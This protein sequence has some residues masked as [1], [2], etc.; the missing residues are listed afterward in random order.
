MPLPLPPNPFS[1]TS[2]C[3]FHLAYSRSLAL[4]SRHLRVAQGG[5]MSVL[6]C[7]RLLGRMILEAPGDAGRMEFS[8]E[9]SRC[10]DDMQLQNVADIYKDHF[11]RICKSKLSPASCSSVFLTINLYT[12]RRAKGRTPAPF[13]H[14]SSSSFNTM[15]NALSHRLL[16]SPRTQ[17]AVKANVCLVRAFIDVPIS[18]LYLGLRARPLPML[19]FRK[20]GHVFCRRSSG[21]GRR[22]L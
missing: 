22:H 7:A 19:I 18:N 21:C 6:V 2:Q 3:L 9:V 4:E 20:T 14:P 8:R 15:Q 1:A 12:V 17:D 13:I 16:E 11:L 5:R 10:G